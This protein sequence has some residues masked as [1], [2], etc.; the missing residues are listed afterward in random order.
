VDLSAVRVFTD[1]ESARTAQAFTARAYTVGQ[2]IH[3]AA[4]RYRPGTSEGDHLI[5]HEVAH[6]VQQGRLP[7]GGH[8]SPVRVTRPDER[9]EREARWAANDLS[10]GHNRRIAERTNLIVALAPPTSETPDIGPQP[11]SRQYWVPESI[12]TKIGSLNFRDITTDELKSLND[13]Q[14][15]DLQ[16]RLDVVEGAIKAAAMVLTARGSKEKQKRQNELVREFITLYWGPRPESKS[17]QEGSVLFRAQQIA[18]RRGFT[19]GVV[20]PFWELTSL[21][22]PFTGD[23]SQFEIWMFEVRQRLNSYS[24]FLFNNVL[25]EVRA[26][27]ELLLRGEAVPE[28]TSEYYKKYGYFTPGYVKAVI[29][30]TEPTLDGLQ[31]FVQFGTRISDAPLQ[32]AEKFDLEIAKEGTPQAVADTVQSIANAVAEGVALTGKHSGD[33]VRGDHDIVTLWYLI[34]EMNSTPGSVYSAQILNENT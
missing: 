4:G 21:F 20:S 5:A 26:Q 7:D 12:A 8:R 9:A 23:E 17:P 25:A 30:L 32:I 3:F 1:A 34:E 19:L 28:K 29:A 14:F 22:T 15:L 10:K 6:T 33:R 2:N 11:D 16:R 31:D 18:R 13:D 27:L 24:L